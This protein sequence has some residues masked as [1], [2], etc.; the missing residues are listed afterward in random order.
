MN[1]NLPVVK[2]P[3]SINPNSTVYFEVPT[4]EYRTE[5][6][7]RNK[8]PLFCELPV[9]AWIVDIGDKYGGEQFS[10]SN[11][12]TRRVRGYFLVEKLPTSVRTSDKL[13]VELD[14]AS[15]TEELRLFFND[16]VSPLQGLVIKS[17]G[18]PFEGYIQIIGGAK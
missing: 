7:T 13:R 16:H 4:G 14:T 2:S 17:L 8:I 18:I 5:K 1:I 12:T 9:K 3:V 6:A 15:S 11:L 10:G